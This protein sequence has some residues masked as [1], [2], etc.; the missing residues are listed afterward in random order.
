MNLQTVTAV[1]FIFSFFITSCE[2]SVTADGYI[3]NETEFLIIKGG[4]GSIIFVEKIGYD[5]VSAFKELEKRKVIEFSRSCPDDPCTEIKLEPFEIEVADK[6]NDRPPEKFFAIMVLNKNTNML[7][8]SV[9]EVITT[10]GD[11]FRMNWCPD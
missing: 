6:N 2:E 1:L 5:F 9:S 7:L 10:R 11:L 4:C 3:E 8:H